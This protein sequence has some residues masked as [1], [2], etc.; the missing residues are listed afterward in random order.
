MKLLAVVSALELKFRLG[1]TPAWWQL[2]K[3]LYETENDVTVIPYLGREIESPW[4]NAA[5]N[6]WRFPGE[7]YYRLSRNVFPKNE[8]GKHTARER[9]AR[10]LSYAVT[11]PV[12]ERYLRKTVRDMRDLDA[13]LFFNVPLNQIKG[14][15]DRLKKEFGV[16]V[17]YYD[18]DMPT[19]LPEY[20]S[21]RGFIFDYYVGGNLSE[22]D[23]FFV[24]SEGAIKTLEE[25]G[26][27][28]VRPLHY[29]ADPEFFRPLDVSREWDIAFFGYGSKY[30]ENWMKKMITEPSL[31]TNFKYAV[32]GAGFDISLGRADN[33]GDISMSAFRRFCCSSRINLNITRES[34]TSVLASSTARPFELAAMG[35]CVVSCP[36][37]GL[38]GW[39]TVGKE[40]EVVSDGD[41]IRGVYQS[42]L[43]DDER[44]NRLGSA[45]RERVLRNHTYQH[46]AVQMRNDLQNLE[47]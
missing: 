45:A 17:A 40:M 26:A 42:L 8:V 28:N 6:P 24:N 44:R 1:C 46:R 23:V 37:S 34:H 32:G 16:K 11:R 47:N 30:R 20:N 36:Y 12:W 31:M 10:V 39:F 19:V 13:V 2:L 15:P 14:I 21:T 35:C 22:Y 38:E 4:W 25:R 18:G 5:K 33:V 29:A 3:A 27:R 9:T 43:H 41:D 7:F